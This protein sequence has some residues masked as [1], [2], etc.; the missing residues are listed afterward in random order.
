MIIAPFREGGFWP[1]GARGG[2][3]EGV[4]VGAAVPLS[5]EAVSLAAARATISELQTKNVIRHIWEQ[6][7]RLKD[8]FNVLARE[9][10]TSNFAECVGLPPRTL[11]MFRDE[12]GNESLVLKSLFQQECLKRGVLFTGS[13]NVFFS[14][15]S[16]DI[17]DTL[18]VYRTALGILAEAIREDNAQQRLEGEI[19]SPVFRRA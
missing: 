17:D 7:A 14:H 1:E 19:V 9:F 12:N 3:L 18:R 13:H 10:G 16:S 6:G 11:V 15:S 8:G 5:G 4:G 2:F